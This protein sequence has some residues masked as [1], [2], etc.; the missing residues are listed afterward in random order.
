MGD[1]VLLVEKEPPI[2][3]LVFN[4][5]EKLNALS[6]AL[7]SAIPA[8]LADFEADPEIRVI[9]VRGA[10]E[11]AFSAGAD[12]GEFKP[13]GRAAEEERP[14]ES[15][16]TLFDVLEGLAR[17]SKP[18]IAMIHGVCMGGGCAAALSIDIRVASE[19]AVFAITPARLG[20]GYAF[21]GIERAVQEI[22]PANARYLFITAGKV[23]ARKALEMGL[24]Q[25]VHAPDELESAT[26]ALAMRVAQN[27]P[28]TIRA[29]KESIRQSVLPPEEREL[30]I[31]NGLIREC[32]ESEDFK[33]G[34]RAFA[35]KRKP[36]FKDR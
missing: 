20:L 6:T 18:T 5:P 29:L 21:E 27:A 2:G 16:G 11:R 15:R 24:V 30:E 12:I 17:C 19:D 7:W 22:G 25:E 31:V 34:V 1:S 14:Q 8:A 32:F 9:V 13:E 4:R 28:K 36:Q 10:G 26:R 3:W 35:E 33:E 23:D